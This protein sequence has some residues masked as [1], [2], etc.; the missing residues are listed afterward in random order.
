MSSVLGPYHFGSDVM[1]LGGKNLV[2]G[3]NV[4]IGRDCFIRAESGLMI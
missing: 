1:L 2:F 3:N 4:N